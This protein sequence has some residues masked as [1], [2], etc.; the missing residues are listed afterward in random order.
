M[1]INSDLIYSKQI[2]VG[3]KRKY[4][5]ANPKFDGIKRNISKR[6]TAI[7]ETFVAF[8]ISLSLGFK[9]IESAISCFSKY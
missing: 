9:K 8:I 7:N 5:L 1:I 4:N 2:K 3:I 6:K